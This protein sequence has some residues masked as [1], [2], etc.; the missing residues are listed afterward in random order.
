MSPRAARRLA[1]PFVLL[2]FVLRPATTL[3]LEPI[4]WRLGSD[5]LGLLVR[6]LLS[7]ASLALPLLAYLVVSR[8]GRQRPATWLLGSSSFTAGASAKWAAPW[9]IILGWAAGGL[10][11]TERVPD[12]ERM[13]LT[14]VQ[15]VATI[16]LVCALLVLGA[17]FILLLLDRPTLTLNAA[18]LTL[19]RYLSPVVI[20][21]PAIEGPPALERRD[22]ILVLKVQGESKPRE[23][24]TDGLHVNPRFLAHT[25]ERYREA[26][27][28]R[29]AIGTTDELR[30][31]ESGFSGPR[32][33]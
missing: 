27:D 12:Q 2:A 5:A 25:I 29:P 19:Q 21:W 14:E 18:G 9:T 4:T 20:G 7:A 3:W 31:L 8:P 28:R 10:I 32:T 33:S 22:R 23:L 24:P 1:I 16:S 6:C 30:A 26:P 11:A 17:S 13:R 15:P